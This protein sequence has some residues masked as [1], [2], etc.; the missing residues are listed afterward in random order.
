[1]AMEDT[2]QESRLPAEYRWASVASREGLDQLTHYKHLLT[3]L[4]DPEEKDA[5]GKLLVVE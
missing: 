4:G 2:D 5:D 1:M 3:S